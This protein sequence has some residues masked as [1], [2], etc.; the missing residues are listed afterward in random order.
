LGSPPS[1]VH[2]FTPG[3]GKEPSALID[4]SMSRAFNNVVLKAKSQTFGAE[5]SK[6][7]LVSDSSQDVSNL[8]KDNSL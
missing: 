8:P 2:A 4:H 7:F 5:D 3:I 6:S 1:K